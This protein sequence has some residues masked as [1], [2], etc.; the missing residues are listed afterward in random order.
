MKIHP[1]IFINIFIVIKT[2]IFNLNGKISFCSNERLKKKWGYETN[3][4]SF[5]S[6]TK[7][8]FTSLTQRLDMLIPFSLLCVLNRMAEP[9][10]Y[11]DLKIMLVTTGPP[12][13]LA[14]KDIPSGFSQRK[15]SNKKNHFQNVYDVLSS[16]D[17]STGLIPTET[18]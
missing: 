3:A 11:K 16:S 7:S 2:E 10:W 6:T 12:V 17:I 8:H 9:Q 18:L 14:D 1:I 15:Y 4:V 5:S 13:Q